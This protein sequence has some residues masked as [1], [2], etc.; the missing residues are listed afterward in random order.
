MRAWVAVVDCVVKGREAT[1]AKVVKAL[2]DD[3]AVVME[4][5]KSCR[6]EH[7]SFVEGKK[8]KERA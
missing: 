2:G 5:V 7:N 3:F 4:L 6:T 1:S 8:R